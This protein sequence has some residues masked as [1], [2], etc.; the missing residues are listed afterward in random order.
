M[1]KL[2]FKRRI[3]HILLSNGE[4]YGLR[5]TRILPYFWWTIGKASSHLPQGLQPTGS[6]VV[7]INYSYTKQQVVEHQRR[8]GGIKVWDKIL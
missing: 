1:S 7:G 4:S 5:Q 3:K 6:L 2:L 8:Y